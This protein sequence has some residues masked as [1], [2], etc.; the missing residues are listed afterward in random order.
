MIQ[1]MKFFLVCLLVLSMVACDEDDE[2]SFSAADLVGTWKAQSFSFSVES[3]R[4]LNG[5]ATTVNTIGT[6]S[7]LDYV[8]ELT[9]ISF[10]TSG[11]Y[12]YSA[13]SEVNGIVTSQKSSTVAGVD[14]SGVIGNGITGS[15]NYS[16][17]G[18]VLTSDASFFEFTFD[19]I[20]L[21]LLVGVQM[22]NYEIN[23]EGKLVLTQ[24]EEI[25]T[26]N[27]EITYTNRVITTST[28]TKQ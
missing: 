17:D 10:V 23:S 2:P 4:S 22:M 15:G 28:W 26:T 13:T 21:G 11:S 14:E 24:N 7:N 25:S 5:M 12:S 18:I 20:D 1:K 16:T 9:E 19:G 3:T 6:G 8:L 27:Q